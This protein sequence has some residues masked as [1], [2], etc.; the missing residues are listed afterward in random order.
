MANSIF[1]TKVFKRLILK[2]T[3][4]I[5]SNRNNVETLFILNHLGKFAKSI[6]SYGS[7]DLPRASLFN[8]KRLDILWAS[9]G[10]SS[11]K[12]WPFKFSSSFCVKFRVSLY[13]IGHNWTSES[14]LWLFEFPRAFVF[15]F[16]NLDILWFATKHPSKN[17]WPFNF[18]WSFHVQFQASW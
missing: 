13:I 18:A 3:S 9:I 17:L 1:F 16:K 12:L 14:K 4:M 6:K 7:L 5:T 11:Q 15:N 8:F 2:F 10:H